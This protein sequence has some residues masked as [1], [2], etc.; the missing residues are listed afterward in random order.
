MLAMECVHSMSS[1]YIFVFSLGDMSAGNLASVLVQPVS[2]YLAKTLLSAPASGHGGLCVPIAMPS[3]A[4]KST[5]YTC[6]S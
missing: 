3:N 5:Q 1:S 2:A 4:G 6:H